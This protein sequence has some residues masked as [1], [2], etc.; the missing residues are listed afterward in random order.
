MTFTITREINGEETE[1]DLVMDFNVIRGCK[2]ARDS[3]GNG[4][5]NGPLLS[6]DEP[7]EIEILSALDSNGEDWDL[8][9]EEFKKFEAE[10]WEYLSDVPDRDDW[11]E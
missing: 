4:I 11:N 10:A 2:G 1:I 8:T 5:N 7:D 3:I 9:D 6:P